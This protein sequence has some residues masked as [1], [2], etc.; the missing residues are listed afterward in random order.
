MLSGWEGHALSPLPIR[1]TLADCRFLQ[2]RVCGRGRIA[3]PSE[4]VASAQDFAEFFRYHCGQK[5]RFLLRFFSKFA[6]QSAV[7]F[8]FFFIWRNRSCTKLLSCTRVQRVWIE[9][10]CLNARCEDVTR[11]ICGNSVKL[12]ALLN[13]AAFPWF[14]DYFCDRDVLEE[15]INGTSCKNSALVVQFSTFISFQ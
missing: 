11:R 5:A 13:I 8:F 3:L 6:M 12:Y 7:F 2:A 9:E 10:L 1:A 4:C 14:C 15:L